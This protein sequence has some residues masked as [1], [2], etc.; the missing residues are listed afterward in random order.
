MIWTYSPPLALVLSF[1]AYS[2]LLHALLFLAKALPLQPKDRVMGRHYGIH[3]GSMYPVPP[4][5]PPLQDGDLAS[6]DHSGLRRSSARR[7]HLKTAARSYSIWSWSL[8]NGAVPPNQNPQ[9]GGLG[10][11]V[12]AALMVRTFT[13]GLPLG[14]VSPYSSGLDIC[15]I[16]I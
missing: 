16:I 7:Y 12:R 8:M 10:V 11:R 13:K 3:Q 15:F 2:L 1:P 9:A 5:D 4:Q 14:P 6:Q